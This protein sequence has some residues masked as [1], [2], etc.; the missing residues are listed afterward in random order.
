MKGAVMRY[1]RDEA[2]AN[3]HVEHEAP[4]QQN[5]CHLHVAHERE[6]QYL[7]EHE[8]ALRD[9]RHNELLERTALTFSARAPWR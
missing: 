4:E 9:R 7:A 8:A 1:S 2:A 3:R 5:H 6:R